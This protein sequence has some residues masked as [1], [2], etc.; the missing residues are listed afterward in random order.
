MSIPVIK[1]VPEVAE[2]ASITPAI[3]QGTAVT[4]LTLAPVN[5]VW[6]V[7]AFEVA[8]PEVSV[9]VFVEEIVAFANTLVGACAIV[10]PSAKV[11]EEVVVVYV[12]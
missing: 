9:P 11:S 5:A 6:F 1:N 7:V 2:A 3:V 4:L 8:L 10:Q 12:P